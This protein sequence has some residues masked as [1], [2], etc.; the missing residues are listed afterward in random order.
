MGHAAYRRKALDVLFPTVRSL[1]N[2]SSDERV[3]APGSR[4]IGA[5]FVHLSGEDSDQTGDAFGEPRVPRRSWSRYLSN[6]PGLVDQLVASRKDSAREGGCPGGKTQAT[7]VFLVRLRAVFRSGFRLDPI[8]SWR[9][10]SS[11]S[12]MSVSSF[13]RTRACGSTCCES[14]RLCAQAWQRRW[15]NSG[16]FSTALFRQPVFTR[17]VDIAPDVG[18]RQSWY[19]RKAGATYFPKELLMIRK[20]RVVAEVNLLPKGLGS[21]TK[22]QWV[23]EN[24]LRKLLTITPSFLVRFRPVKYGIE[25]LDI[26]YTLV[27]GWS[28]RASFWSGQWSGQTLVKLGQP[29][30][31][32]V[33]FGQSS[34]NS[35]KC[36]PE[37]HF[38]GFWARWVL[39]GLETARSNLGQTLVNPSQTWSTLVK[40]GQ[41]LGNVSR[42]FFLGVFDATR[43]RWI[44]RAGSGSPRL[45]CRHPRK[46]RTGTQT[47]T[48]CATAVGE[49]G[50]REN[51]SGQKSSHLFFVQRSLCQEMPNKEGA[52]VITPFLPHGIFSGVGAQ[53]GTARTE[54]ALILTT[55]RRIKYSQEE[56]PGHISRAY[57]GGNVC[58]KILSDPLQLGPRAKT[59]RQ[60]VHFSY[61]MQLSDRQEL[62]RSSRNL[63]QKMT[64][65]HKE[66]SDGLRSQD[67][68]L[69]TQTRLCAR[70]VPLEKVFLTRNKLI[71]E[72][73]HIG[74][75]THPCTTWN[76]RIAKNL[77][78]SS[79][80]PDRKTALKRTKNTPVDSARGAISHKS[81][82]GFPRIRNLAKSRQR[83]LSDGTKNVK[84]RHRELGQIC[85]RTG[86][87]FE[88]KRA[89]SKTHFFSRTA[90]F[91]RRVFPARNKLIREP[92]CVGKI[93]TPAT[94]WNSRFA[95]SIP[96]LTGI[97]HRKSAQK[98]LRHPDFREP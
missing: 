57:L 74:K 89:G 93:M 33:E 22:L 3:M 87:R 21:W 52:T 79:R 20:L 35:W 88:K 12:C 18:F 5:V 63:S 98:Q 81:K 78:G 47:E 34:P 30:S 69:R 11:T 64:P 95:D 28:V 77:S 92:G 44:M 26:L 73:G 25:A 59:L 51:P 97:L 54:P 16:N 14:G 56:G 55:L 96:R 70:P 29:W 8:K 23:G 72:P 45:A 17:M 10:E 80:N 46:S 65:W 37:L 48:N 82:L 75:K 1:L 91:A 53:N 36:I 86:T 83:K 85:A 41:T 2:R 15:E 38:K 27:K 19:R 9:S 66:H 42:T 67:H 90:A 24:L 61:H 94:S 68:I 84:I 60:E 7:G 50:N 39:V 31:N 13:Q 32:L 58:A 6:A 62:L 4:G 76:S 43:L 71:C 49:R 40:L